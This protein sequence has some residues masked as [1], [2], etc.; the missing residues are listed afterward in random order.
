MHTHPP[1]KSVSAHK[2]WRRGHT[3]VQNSR[4]H[5]ATDVWEQKGVK[6][7][8]LKTIKKITTESL[9]PLSPDCSV[10]SAASQLQWAT[11]NPFAVLVEDRNKHMDQVIESRWVVINENEQWGIFSL[12][13]VMLHSP[14]WSC[15]Y[16][17]T[18]ATVIQPL[19][20][21]IFFTPHMT[22][23]RVSCMP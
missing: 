21:T 3:V 23:W 19:P 5:D 12:V 9:T 18:T 2:S 15:M 14:S 4:T 13:A 22:P 7:P 17:S 8:I 6:C 10:H 11:L 20:T 1:T 16:R